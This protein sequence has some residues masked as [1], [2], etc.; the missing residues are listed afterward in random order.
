MCTNL[1]LLH[2]AGRVTDGGDGRRQRALRPLPG[3]GC[4]GSLLCRGRMTGTFTSRA[5]EALSPGAET[6]DGRGNQQT[7][8]PRPASL[9]QPLLVAALYTPLWAGCGPFPPQATLWSGR[10]TCR[11]GFRE[12]PCPLLASMGSPS[13]KWEG[14]E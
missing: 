7:P 1:S 6:Q 5:G 2:A 13:S 11:D 12:Q 14:R 4:S 9:G 8:A 3:P 10:P